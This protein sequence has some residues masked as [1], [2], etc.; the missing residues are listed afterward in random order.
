MTPSTSVALDHVLF[1]TRSLGPASATLMRTYGLASVPGGR[2]PGHGTENRI[3]PLGNTYL[4]L[5]TAADPVEASAS[6]F[7]RRVSEAAR[8]GG[9]FALC[10]RVPRVQP[11]ARR[12]GLPIVEMSRELPDGAVLRWRLAGLAAA[13]GD[14]A[15]PFFIE[16]RISPASFPGRQPAMHRCRPQGLA[17][18]EVGGHPGRLRQWTGGEVRGLTA[19]GGP[20]GIRRVLVATRT[21]TI[22]LNGPEPCARDGVAAGAR[23]R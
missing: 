10:L 19:V 14:E 1:A 13:M 6:P 20:P 22:E 16:W 15:L 18:V 8:R 2:H 5:V 12:L 9:P 4:E 23:T 3:V 17:S 7:G 21:R 11:V